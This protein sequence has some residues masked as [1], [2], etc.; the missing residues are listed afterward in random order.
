MN[1]SEL[2][3]ATGTD[4][5]ALGRVLRA[6]CA[7][8]VFTT[9]PSGHISL[10]PIGGLLRSD[11][12]GSWR[13]GMRFTAGPVRWRCW[14]RL[15]DAVRTGTNAAERVLGGQLFDFY[16]SNPDESRIHDDAMRSF[17]AGHATAIVAALDLN[18]ARVVVDVGGGTAEML[19][20][21]LGAHPH[22]RGVLFDL[23]N[24]T[25]HSREVLAAHGVADRCRVEC[26][27]FFEHVPEDGDVYILKNIIHDW[28]D[29]RAAEILRSCR[30]C[31]P[32]HA[33][34]LLVEREMPEVAAAG[35]SVEAFLTDL[36]M[37]VMSPDGR[38]R[39]AAEFRTLLSNS[40]FQ[41]RGAKR[42]ASPLS[43]FEAR[44]E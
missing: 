1:N 31:I 19:S 17:S 22:L 44:P 14:A 38:E 41:L 29:E 23:P 10:S 26:G 42:T 11:V 20:A 34:L 27:S 6:L 35:A 3:A 15:L 8:G 32:N 40:G 16:A 33:R 7:L 4:A 37:L 18:E 30:R 39:T 21:I 24:V 12:P 5:K 43:I 25:L 28:D 2:A 13:A 9:S 36:E